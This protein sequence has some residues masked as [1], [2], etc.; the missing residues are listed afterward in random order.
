VGEKF[1]GSINR[2]RTIDALGRR[3][4]LFHVSPLINRQLIMVIDGQEDPLIRHRDYRVE[5]SAT[6]ILIETQLIMKFFPPLSLQL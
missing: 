4:A 5:I 3:D 2:V 1:G 6:I